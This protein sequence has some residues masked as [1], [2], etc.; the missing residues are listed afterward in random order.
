MKMYKV[1][2]TLPTDWVG[3]DYEEEFEF[4]YDDDMEEDEIRSEIQSEFEDWVDD[5]LNDMRSWSDWEILDYG[6]ISE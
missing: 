5:K 3:A 2:F 4:E 1:L 6:E